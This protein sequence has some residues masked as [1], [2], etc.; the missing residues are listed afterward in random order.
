MKRT[1][2]RPAPLSDEQWARVTARDTDAARAFLYG[3]STTRIYCRPG[4]PARLPKRAHAVAFGDAREAQRCGYRP[5]KLCAPDRALSPERE[6]I[7]RAKHLC[8]R[9]AESQTSESEADPEDGPEDGPEAAL[10]ISGSQLTRLFVRSEGETPA[11]YARGLRI[12]AAQT[13][14]RTTRMS[15]PEIALRAGFQSL[16]GFYAAFRAEVGAT[17]ARY[18]AEKR[19]LK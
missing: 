11:R 8:A 12:A 16:S 9:R 14:L 19:E 10:G 18:R 15:V 5:C 4:C 17:P 7:E 6:L 3:V 13:L 2:T 1:Q